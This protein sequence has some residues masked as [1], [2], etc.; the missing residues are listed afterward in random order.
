[1]KI[2]YTCVSLVLFV[3]NV[4]NSNEISECYSK[5]ITLG[6][7]SFEN[8]NYKKSV[9]FYKESYICSSNRKQKIVSLASIATSKYKANDIKESKIYLERLLLI[10]PENQWAKEFKKKYEEEKPLNKIPMRKIKKHKE[11]NK[12]SEKKEIKIEVIVNGNPITVMLEVKIDSNGKENIVNNFKN[13]TSAFYTAPK[14]TCASLINNRII[15]KLVGSNGSE[16]ILFLKKH[17]NRARD[18]NLTYRNY[19]VI[20]HTKSV[21]NGKT[22]T[23]LGVN[24]DC[25]KKIKTVLYVNNNDK[26]KKLDDC[27]FKIN[28]MN[29]DDMESDRMYDK[30]CLNISDHQISEKYR[31]KLMDY[32]EKELLPKLYEVS[33]SYPSDENKVVES[34]QELLPNSDESNTIP[35]PKKLLSSSSKTDY[36][37]K[38]DMTEIYKKQSTSQ[39]ENNNLQKIVSNKKNYI[40]I[41]KKLFN[42]KFIKNR[43]KKRRR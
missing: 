17:M 19:L 34:S 18:K 40:K 42:S 25:N 23:M 12:S 35:T 13:K 24:T 37:N 28:A 29:L 1:M 14:Y 36:S 21:M 16:H 9:N 27:L 31:H 6:N 22:A 43:M 26:N 30:L 3:T 8:K 41:T 39:S 20:E 32:N 15:A 38:N 7:S 11:N 5:N 2:I 10:S 4:S 33:K